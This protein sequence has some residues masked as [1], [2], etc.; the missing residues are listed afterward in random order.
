M[1]INEI[2]E[3]RQKTHGN[4]TTHA[5]ISQNLKEIARNGRNWAKLEPYQKEAID[6]CFHKIARVLDGN[7]D[8]IDSWRDAAGY[9]ELATRELTK[10]DGALDSVVSYK[11]NN[12]DCLNSKDN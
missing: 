6:M 8:Y 2:L 10:K 11:V 3:E 5:L 1:E 4:F 7:Q 12:K 9:I